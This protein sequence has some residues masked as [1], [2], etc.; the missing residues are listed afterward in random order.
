LK[1]QVYTITAFINGKKYKTTFQA[2]ATQAS[3]ELDKH[4][5]STDVGY[6]SFNAIERQ[7]GG[8]EY[9]TTSNDLAQSLL[10]TISPQGYLVLGKNIEAPLQFS[11][12]THGESGQV[13]LKGKAQL[14]GEVVLDYKVKTSLSK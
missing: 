1:Q 11:T 6:I 4:I 12:T 7:S 14:R 9:I 13:T 8:T 5:T 3:S 10:N 2:Y